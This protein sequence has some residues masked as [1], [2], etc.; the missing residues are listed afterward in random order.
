MVFKKMY[1]KKPPGHTY[2]NVPDMNAQGHGDPMGTAIDLALLRHHWDGG[3]GL[4]D[5][6]TH[7]GRGIKS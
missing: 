3:K 6:V 2:C 4:G 7:V 1:R 5:G